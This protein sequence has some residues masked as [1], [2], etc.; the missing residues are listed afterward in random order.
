MSHVSC[1]GQ[2]NAKGAKQFTLRA[3]VKTLPAGHLARR[4]YD[5]IA[6][7]MAEAHELLHTLGGN[8]ALEH[9]LREARAILGGE[10]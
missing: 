4:E 2:N 6:R 10:L 3:W 1:A 5:D 9:R 8:S 7:A